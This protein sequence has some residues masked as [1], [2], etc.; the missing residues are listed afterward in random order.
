MIQTDNFKMQL[1]EL[2][3]D[4]F[5]YMMTLIAREF[6]FHEHVNEFLRLRLTCR[7]LDAEVLHAL[8]TPAFFQYKRKIRTSQTAAFFKQPSVSVPSSKE[9]VP[10]PSSY[11]DF[12]ASYLNVRPHLQ[13]PW[14]SNISSVV[15]HVV[16]AL[17]SADGLDMNDEKR[18]TIMRDLCRHVF[19][20]RHWKTNLH[21]F[22]E[23]LFPSS[24]INFSNAT[25]SLDFNELLANVVLGRRTSLADQD[26]SALMARKS[27]ILGTLLQACIKSGQVVLVTSLLDTGVD[28]NDVSLEVLETAVESD[29][30]EML[31]LIFSPKYNLS[32]SVHLT[33]RIK[34]AIQTAVKNDRTEAMLYLSRTCDMSA[35]PKE[36][37]FA[38]GHACCHNNFCI[39]TVLLDELKA[40]GSS[41][42][43]EQYQWILPQVVFYGHQNMVRFLLD[44][45]VQYKANML[46]L[47]AASSGDLPMARFLLR[48]CE[49]NFSAATWCEVLAEAIAHATPHHFAFAEAV[50]S[51]PSLFEKQTLSVESLFQD[52]SCN[53]G[54]LFTQACY[55]GNELIVRKIAEGGANLDHLEGYM[56]PVMTAQCYGQSALVDVLIE[57]GAKPIDPMETEYRAQFE[58]GQFPTPQRKKP[59]TV[60]RS[61]WW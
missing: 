11:L 47:S 10:L 13:D 14:N 26:I 33:S 37:A 46:M 25:D 53:Y 17:L 18:K 39:A 61:Y 60:D 9:R 38:F 23:L 44:Q 19:E 55:F 52:R 20:M 4:C 27:I 45:G 56:P 12:F 31:Q 8:Q 54:E 50:L 43:E 36:I 16:D 40:M 59:V 28:V 42:E 29:K 48:E 7:T 1:L 57:L 49:M 15:N 51:D 3:L 58:T 24:H 35:I 30:E 21:S 22:S 2:P 32:R 34:K 41:L 5:R 6:D